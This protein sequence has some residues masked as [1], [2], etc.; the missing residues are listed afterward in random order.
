MLPKS[1]TRMSPTTNPVTGAKTQSAGHR[2]HGADSNRFEALRSR[3]IFATGFEA[4]GRV[5]DDLF[6]SAHALSKLC[7][8]SYCRYS[9]V[10]T[11]PRAREAMRSRVCGLGPNPPEPKL[12][13]VSIMSSCFCLAVSTR[14]GCWAAV[15]IGSLRL[16]VLGAAASSGFFLSLSTNRGLHVASAAHADSDSHLLSKRRPDVMYGKL[17][18]VIGI[19][20]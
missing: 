13:M 15:G 18:G 12:A 16:L 6:G 5:L 14:S 10:V 7:S 2:Q 17:L 11:S 19:F 4:L 3:D 8:F 20:L 1:H 9:S